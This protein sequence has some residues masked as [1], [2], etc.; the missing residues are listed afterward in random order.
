MGFRERRHNG[1]SWIELLLG[2]IQEVLLL[3]MALCIIESIAFSF[4]VIVNKHVIVYHSVFINSFFKNTLIIPDI[5]AFYGSQKA[6]IYA[7]KSAGINYY[8][9]LCT[10]LF[11]NMLLLCEVNY[12][13]GK[14]NK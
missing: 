8:C 6:I 9:R 10:G 13:D 7:P 12:F 5:S 1:V 11:H 2:L 4:F 3:A 14:V